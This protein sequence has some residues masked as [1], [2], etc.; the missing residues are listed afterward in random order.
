[1]IKVGDVYHL[2]VAYEDKDAAKAAGARWNPREKCWYA[3]DRETA[4]KAQAAAD[5][6]RAR[7]LEAEKAQREAELAAQRQEELEEAKRVSACKDVASFFTIDKKAGK[8]SIN[9]DLQAALA[10]VKELYRIR[11]KKTSL[12][13]DEERELRDIYY[14]YQE[15]FDAF[16]LPSGT[17]NS[18]HCELLRLAHDK[19]FRLRRALEY[20][21]E[22]A[23]IRL[24]RKLEAAAK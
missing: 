17:R 6:H 13:A 14:E 4:V 3:A 8:V 5:K 19:L 20:V 22:A 15:L 9:A 24:K 1:M 16:E 21:R 10:R 18:T 2:T 11:E 7:R 23:E 12:H